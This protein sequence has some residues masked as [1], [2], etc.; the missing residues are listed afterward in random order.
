MWIVKPQN[1]SIL[2]SKQR[3]I[4]QCSKC[5]EHGV[6]WSGT[7]KSEFPQTTK[8]TLNEKTLENVT[9][10]FN[11]WKEPRNQKFGLRWREK[12]ISQKSPK[13]FLQSKFQK[14]MIWNL[15]SCAKN[16]FKKTCTK[17]NLSLEG[18]QEVLRKKQLNLQ[19]VE[20]MALWPKQARAVS[21]ARVWFPGQQNR[22]KRVMVAHDC[23]PSRGMPLI[24]CM[25]LEQSWVWFQFPSHGCSWPL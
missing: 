20:A 24:G 1:E 3:A 25:Y 23:Y 15:K 11:C 7:W 5:F 8:K 16:C 19:P 22:S 13:N 14:Y 10:M 12:I 2:L 18:C 21:L 9:L 4:S 6:G 17:L